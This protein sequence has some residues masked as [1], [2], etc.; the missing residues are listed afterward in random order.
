MKIIFMGTSEFAV[1]SLAKL[2]ESGHDVIEVVSQ[3]D[4]PKGR[5]K[6]IIPTPVKTAALNHDIPVYQ[7]LKIKNAEAVTHIHSLKPDVI[8]VVSYGQIIPPA[9]LDYPRFGCINV[10][11]SL[12]PEFRGAAP[13][14]RALM[15]GRKVTG[16]TTMYMDEGLDTGDIIMQNQFTLS[17]DI[18]HGQ[19]EAILSEKGADLLIDT[20]K[21]LENG[22]VVRIPQ[23]NE[24]STY[25][26]MIT[27]ED[28]YINWDD[29]AV[30]LHNRIRALCPRP[31]AYTTI[32]G[33]K[34]K[35]FKSRVVN[36]NGNGVIG[37]VDRLSNEGF[38]V[39]TGKGLLEVME[40]QKEG[41]K[42][43]SSRDFLKGFKLEPGIVLGN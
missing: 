11:A 27:R 18:D 14:Q 28:E 4:K 25:A 5:G 7:P 39:Q 16:V 30:S 42:R 41:K 8:V 32:D 31:G 34:L 23:D 13:V 36:T 29:T 9:I 20:L 37:Q 3:P 22:S 2:I 10:H 35:I 12:L 21:S 33:M 24:E 19:L 40:I 17:E 6:K 15:E 1:S 38:V 26:G 43:M